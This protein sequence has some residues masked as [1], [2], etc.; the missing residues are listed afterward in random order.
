MFLKRKGLLSLLHM[1]PPF[2][3]KRDWK[4]FK[5]LANERPK[6]DFN[7]AQYYFLTKNVEIFFLE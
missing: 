4:G 1:E 7:F 6:L 2:P 3:G 5:P